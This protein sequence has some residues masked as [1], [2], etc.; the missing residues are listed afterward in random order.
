MGNIIWQEDSDYY[1]LAPLTDEM[2]K[3]AEEKLKIK[4][5]Q[6]YINILKDQNG[7]YIKFNS[8]PTDVPTSWADDHINVEYIWGISLEDGILKSE[9]FIEEWEMPE[10]LVLFNGD[11]HT[12]IAFDYRHVSSEPPIVYI[13]NEEEKIIKTILMNF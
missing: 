10:G 7:G 12:W 8:Y 4:L 13:D 5:P 9:Y 3:K 6:S 1:K 2:V 11:G